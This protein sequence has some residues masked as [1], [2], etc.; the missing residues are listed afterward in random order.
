MLELQLQ[1]VTGTGTDV[2]QKVVELLAAGGGGGV[3]VSDGAEVAVTL[4]GVGVVIEMSV[5]EVGDAD[6]VLGS[7]LV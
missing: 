2:A 7:A 3:C 6:V 5:V 4:D 1:L